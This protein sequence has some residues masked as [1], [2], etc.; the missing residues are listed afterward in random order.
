[1]FEFE[2]IKSLNTYVGVSTNFDNAIVFLSDFYPLKMLPLV[3]ILCWFWFSEN[4]SD[5]KVREMIIKGVVGSFLAMFVARMLSKT[6]PFRLRPLHEPNLLLNIP[7]T[8]PSWA[9]SGWSSMPSDNATLG[10]A[11][12]TTILLIHHK[13]GIFAYLQVLF[14]VCFPRLYLSL[15]YPTDIL[16]GGIL[17]IVVNFATIKTKL[18]DP[19]IN[20]VLI[21]EDKFP[22]SFYVFATAL[23]LEFVMMFKIS[24]SCVN[25]VLIYFNIDL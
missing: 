12:A 19:I 3:I 4:N 20:K 6:L 25:Y 13:W 22:K 10:F 7:D 11:L 1:M 21:I 14:L 17:G 2:L 24:R 18:L 23:A 15:H 9:L 16:L 5:T 8:M